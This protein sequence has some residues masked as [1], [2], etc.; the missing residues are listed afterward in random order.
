MGIL[1]TL[2]GNDAADASKAAAADTYQK[3]QDAVKSLLG[4]GDTLPGAY[5]ALS[6]KFAPYGEAGNAALTQL[7]SGLGLGGPEGSAAFTSAYRSLPGYEAGLESGSK[8]IAS[9]GAAKGM[10]NSGRTLKGLTRFGSDYEDQRSGDYLTRLMG[11]SGMGQT[12]TGQQVATAGQGLQGQTQTRLAG[13]GGQ[14]GSAGTVGQGDIAGANAQAQ[15]WQNLL[16]FGGNL[17]GKAMGSDWV[18]KA[19]G[20]G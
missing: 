13:Y 11:L 14:Y 16:N 6:E 17:A 2:L 19:M 4:Y 18:G 1:D 15:G 9:S 3:Q 5:S 12:A 20:F 7:M 10:L 8:A